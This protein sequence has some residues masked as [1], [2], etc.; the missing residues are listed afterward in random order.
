MPLHFGKGCGAASLTYKII[1][2]Q[3]RISP[4]SSLTL[5]MASTGAALHVPIYFQLQFGIEL[6]PARVNCC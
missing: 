6:S 5:V 2:H 4:E 3:S 1:D